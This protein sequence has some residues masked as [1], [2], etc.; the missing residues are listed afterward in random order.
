MLLEGSS[1][2]PTQILPPGCVLQS[3]DR[4]S[5]L[6]GQPL[7]DGRHD[8]EDVVPDF[9]KR[10]SR[11]CIP[12]CPVVD[13][14]REL[15]RGLRDLVS[16]PL[17]STLW[18]VSWPWKSRQIPTRRELFFLC[19]T[20]KINN[21]YSLITNYILFYIL[22]FKFRKQNNIINKSRNNVNIGSVGF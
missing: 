4:Q 9:D 17:H 21:N 8:L 2:L 3:T 19:C 7:D 5:C 10:P 13:I 16:P 12:H 20:I 6:R 1:D 11:R 14:W 15:V 18:Q 22:S